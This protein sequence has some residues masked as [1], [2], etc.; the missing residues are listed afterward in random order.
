M[1][2]D[3]SERDYFPKEFLVHID[4]LVDDLAVTDYGVHEKHKK[5]GSTKV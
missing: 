1:Y 2:S 4:T 3:Q 5:K